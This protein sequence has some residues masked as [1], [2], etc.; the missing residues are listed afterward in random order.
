M[1]TKKINKDIEEL[2]LSSDIETSN[3]LNFKSVFKYQKYK[4][5]GSSLDYEKM[6]KVTSPNVEL[7]INKLGKEDFIIDSKHFWL[8]TNEVVDGLIISGKGFGTRLEIVADKKV[9]ETKILSFYEEYINFI[10]AL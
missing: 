2:Y 8:V 4:F 7:L 10:L 9:K 5:Y 3:A 6:M 1:I